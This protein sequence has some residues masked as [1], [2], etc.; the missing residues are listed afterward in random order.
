V[1]LARANDKFAARFRVLEEMVAAKGEEMRS[2][3][4]AELD[5]VWER[6]KQVT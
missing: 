3:T 2:L 6:A 4:L 1:A 5:A